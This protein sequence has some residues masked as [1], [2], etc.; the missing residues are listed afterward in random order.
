MGARLRFNDERWKEEES[1]RY[2]AEA[3]STKDD[4][5]IAYFFLLLL[6]L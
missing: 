2:K 6:L 3:K 5:I 4:I 1:T